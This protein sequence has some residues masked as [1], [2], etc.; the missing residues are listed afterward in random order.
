MPSIRSDAISG[1]SISPGVTSLRASGPLRVLRTSLSAIP[2][3]F[4]NNPDTGPDH[5]IAKTE[6]SCL[7]FKRRDLFAGY[8]QGR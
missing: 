5:P 6:K 7:G 8:T 3:S 1:D 2:V 4:V